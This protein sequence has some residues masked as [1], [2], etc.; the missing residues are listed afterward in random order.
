MMAYG[1][2]A[3]DS[4]RYYRHFPENS[5]LAEFLKA[6]ELRYVEFGVGHIACL[7]QLDS[8]FAVSFNPANGV[9]LYGLSNFGKHV[10]TSF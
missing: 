1:A 7:V 5:A 8:H 10:F 2:N 9:D 3:A 4:R 6:S